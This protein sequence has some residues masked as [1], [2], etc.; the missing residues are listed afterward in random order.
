MVV[1]DENGNYKPIDR[2]SIED[3]AVPLAD[4][5]LDAETEAD[6]NEDID[7]A[8]TIEDGDVAKAAMAEEETTQKIFTS[9]K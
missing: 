2:V 1:K 3:E 5:A 6:N 7:G 4:G 8:T 9:M